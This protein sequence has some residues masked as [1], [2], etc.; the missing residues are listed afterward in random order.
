[1]LA[2]LAALLLGAPP[3]SPVGAAAVFH[4]VP[5]EI[6]VRDLPETGKAVEQA[7]AAV[8]ELER[9]LGEGTAALN[10]AAGQG[11]QA[12]DPLLL[13]LLT[14][15]RDFCI[16]SETAHGPLGRALY[17]L[18][19]PAAEVPAPE[20]LMQA[21]ELASCDRLGIDPAK[22]TASLG[23]GA[24]LDLRGFAEGAAVDRAVEVL[25]QAGAVNGFVR[26][27]DARRGFGAG[28]AGKGWPVVL[29]PVPGMDEPAGRLFLRD[30]SLAFTLRGERAILNQ[31]TGRPAEGT[32]AV[33]AAAELAVDAQALATTLLITGPREGQLRLG[34]LQPKPAALWLLGSG[35]GPPLLVEYRW[36]QVPKQ[37]P[38]R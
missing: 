11:H 27:G 17:A 21:V 23:K 38:K 4:G 13:A 8:A 18:W 32:L 9:L 2:F 5:V 25:R 1:M 26:I 28:P 6:E 14:R 30:Q 19:M 29:G 37:T 34:S 35:N 10:A 15:A 33:A 24:G 16:W 36:S 31:R 7:Q 22:G 3:A 12:V 20:R